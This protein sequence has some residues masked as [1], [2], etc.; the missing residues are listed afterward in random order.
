MRKEWKYEQLTETLIGE[1]VSSLRATPCI[2]LPRYPIVDD[3]SRSTSF[4]HY[5]SRGF[6]GECFG[7][8][9]E[10][11]RVCLLSSSLSLLFVLLIILFFSLVH[12]FSASLLLF[13]CF[14]SLSL[15]LRLSIFS[16]YFCLS[17]YLVLFFVNL[18]PSFGHL[19]SLNPTFF[20]FFCWG[21]GVGRFRVRWGLKGH[22]TSP[23]PSFFWFYFFLGGGETRKAIFQQ[24]WWFLASLTANFRFYPFQ[25]LSV[26][27]MDPFQKTFFLQFLYFCCFLYFCFIQKRFSK[28]SLF[29]TQ[30]AF[31][32]C[33]V[34]VLFGLFFVLVLWFSLFWS[35]LRVAS[36]LYQPPVLT[37]VKNIVAICYCFWGTFKQ[38][39][40]YKSREIMTFGCYNPTSPCAK[41]IT[42]VK[43]RVLHLAIIERPMFRKRAEY[44]FEST[45]SEEGTH[46]VLGQTRWVLRKTR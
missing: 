4:S 15:S 25:K 28:T 22:L 42:T 33:V 46:R 6:R 31:M 19:T 38:H 27:F 13:F 23:N 21:G 17:Q 11:L 45:V 18:F 29:Q 16:F 3:I 41:T 7:V 14:L 2:Y 24:F 44:C 9:F 40:N 32:F 12:S 36:V 10:C 20:V 43:R 37:N 35:K 39:M 34:Y 1:K 5:T 30:F 8:V 26:F